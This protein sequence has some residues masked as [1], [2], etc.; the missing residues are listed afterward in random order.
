MLVKLTPT[1]PPSLQEMKTIPISLA[2]VEEET[3]E[4]EG[5]ITIVK[6]DFSLSYHFFNNDDDGDRR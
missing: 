3:R 1:L 4:R 6:C 2:E 5:R